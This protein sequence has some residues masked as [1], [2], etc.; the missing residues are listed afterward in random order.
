[1]SGLCGA[2]AVVAASLGAGAAGRASPCSPV[3]TAYRLSR[4]CEWEGHTQALSK[5]LG[6]GEVW[7]SVG[8]GVSEYTLVFQR[9][10]GRKT[11]KASRAWVVVRPTPERRA[12]ARHA[13][14]PDVAEVFAVP[15]CSA[16][17]LDGAAYEYF[18]S[19][20]GVLNDIVGMLARRSVRSLADAETVR[21]EIQSLVMAAEVQHI[22][23]R[24]SA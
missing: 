19:T 21:K 15:I 3:V 11:D 1:M 6:C 5:R 4:Q 20:S 9:G 13:Q 23:E 18:L 24:M 12:P 17:A 22:V 8:Y 14:T 10:A 7:V 2:I 16:L